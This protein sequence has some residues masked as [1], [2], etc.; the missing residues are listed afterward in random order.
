M[1]NR[2]FVFISVLIASAVGAALAAFAQSS[3]ATKG[4]GTAQTAQISIT[5]H[6]ANPAPADRTGIAE[7]K[8]GK[9]DAIAFDRLRQ[10]LDKLGPDRKPPIFLNSPGGSLSGSL[11]LGRLIRENK[12]ETRVGHTV[13]LG[14]DTDKPDKLAGLQQHAKRLRQAGPI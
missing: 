7:Q 2:A 10:L 3:P 13:P 6:T 14:C 4:N 9:I 11:A 8:L 1:P 5:W 12:L